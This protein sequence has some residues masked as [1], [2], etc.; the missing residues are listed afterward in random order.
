MKLWII[1]F[2]SSALLYGI[3]EYLSKM[4]ANTGGSLSLCSA[5]ILYCII[6]ALWFPAL[7][8]HNQLAVMT[9]IWTMMYI[10]VGSFVGVAFCHEKL[11][12]MQWIGIVFAVISSILLL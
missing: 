2:L 12:V 1:C 6:S 4:Y 10:I 8:Q 11:T 7:R 5:F 3:A 9:V